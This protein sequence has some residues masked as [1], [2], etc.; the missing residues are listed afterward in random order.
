MKNKLFNM[1]AVMLI[2]ALST[3]PVSA[4][5]FKLTSSFK[6]GSLIAYGDISGLGRTD[7][8]L[9]LDASGLA[10]TICKNPGQND[11]P[12]QSYPKVSAS[13]FQSLSGNDTTRKNG[14]APFSAET[15]DPT[16]IGAGLAGCPSSQWTA[17]VANILWTNATITV[18]QGFDAP[19]G[20][21]LL[22]K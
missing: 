1:L 3:S 18:H 22:T 15:V 12:G 17:R 10:A 9:V 13:G 20:P 2:A 14:K 4:A 8:T 21:V 16:A 5:S 7:V 19:N 6:L 11:V